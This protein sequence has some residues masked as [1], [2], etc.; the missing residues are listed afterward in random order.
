MPRHGQ[1]NMRHI[2]PVRESGPLPAYDGTYTMEDIRNIYDKTCVG[3]DF[4]P[5]SHLPE[6]I[7]RRVPG[8]TRKEAEHITRYDFFSGT[9]LVDFWPGIFYMDSRARLQK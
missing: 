2:L 7:M 5:C 3:R 4:H 9:G 8:I 6:E 1:R